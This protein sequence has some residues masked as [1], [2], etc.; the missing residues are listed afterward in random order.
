MVVAAVLL[1]AGLGVDGI[2]HD[3][4]QEIA[5]R[6]VA[7][8][9]GAVVGF[10]INKGF[11]TDDDFLQFEVAI[12]QGDTSV[13]EVGH[14][15]VDRFKGHMGDG[16]LSCSLHIGEYAVDVGGPDKYAIVVEHTGQGHAPTLLINHLQ[17]LGA[18]A[19]GSHQRSHYQKNIFSH[20]LYKV[21]NTS[22]Y[23]AAKIRI[24]QHLCKETDKKIRLA[25]CQDRWRRDPACP[26]EETRA[27]RLWTA[28]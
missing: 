12:L 8:D 2:G 25:L 17:A 3:A 5:E 23:Y 26:A 14:V 19:K 13:G 27:R 1:L 21:K 15:H 16:D 24:K 11:G 9:I 10:D 20:A 22:F 4:C 18:C 28:R 7:V 6:V